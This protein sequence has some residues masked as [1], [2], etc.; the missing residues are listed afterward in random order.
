MPQ[1][2]S[3]F[4]QVAHTKAGAYSGHVRRAPVAHTHPVIRRHPVTGEK[5]LYVNSGFT[6]RIVGLRKEE[7]DTIL[8][9]LFDHIAKGADFQA[10]VRWQPHTVVVSAARPLLA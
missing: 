2:H 6:R 5:S 10:R 3:G 1:V 7:S 8:Q 4:E 9:F